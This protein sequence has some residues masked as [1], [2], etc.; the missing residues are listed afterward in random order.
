MLLLHLHIDA[1]CVIIALLEITN[2]HTKMR[3]FV[4]LSADEMGRRKRDEG[5]DE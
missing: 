2:H 1:L 5:G 3:K 4:C